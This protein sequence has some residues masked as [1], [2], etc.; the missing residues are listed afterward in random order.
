MHQTVFDAVAA[1]HHN[2]YE[3]VRVNIYQIE[4]ADRHR[5]LA[6]QRQRG[7]VGELGNEPAHVADRVVKLLHLLVHTAVHLLRLLQRELLLFHQLVDVHPVAQ[8]GGHTAGRGVR[9]FEIAQRHKLR[10]LVAYRRRRAAKPCVLRDGLAADR[11]RGLDI[12]VDH[13]GKYFLFPIAYD[14]FNIHRLALAFP[15][16]WHSYLSSANIPPAHDSVNSF[17][18][19]VL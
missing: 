15:D 11:L 1:E 2:D 9:L 3:G 14:H 10:K 6:C 18:A 19:D 7:E 4:P 13:S 12:F 8:R 16:C 5:G 17:C